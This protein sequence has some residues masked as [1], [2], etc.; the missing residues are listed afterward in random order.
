MDV[1]DRIKS[2]RSKLG[3][4]QQQLAFDTGLSIDGIRS[5][6]SGRAKP[7]IETLGK[8]ADRF[9]CTTDYLL[10]RTND[11]S[12]SKNYTWQEAHELLETMA[13]LFDRVGEKEGQSIRDWK[14]SYPDPDAEM[15]DDEQ[16]K[17][18]KMFDE[19]NDLLLQ[20]EKNIIAI[21]DGDADIQNKK[22]S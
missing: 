21:R 14:N 20:A 6:E 8:L 16:E 12:A 2:E 1:K 18:S 19:V 4:T 13:K 17:M 15:T 22:D 9:G 7:N 3:I 11:P 10:G 5:I